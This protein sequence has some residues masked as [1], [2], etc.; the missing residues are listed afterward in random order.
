[1]AKVAPLETTSGATLSIRKVGV[2]LGI[3]KSDYSE[4]VR[5]AG[6]KGQLSQNTL[7]VSVLRNLIAARISNTFNFYG[8]S[9]ALDTACSS[10]LVAL[11]LAKESILSGQV[12]WL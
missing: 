12:T 2:F 5:E 3:S 7:L 10:S 6:L 8:P 1:M 9:M 11:H 4:L